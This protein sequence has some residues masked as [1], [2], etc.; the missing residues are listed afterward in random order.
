MWRSW[1]PGDLAHGQNHTYSTTLV[2]PESRTSPFKGRP[3]PAAT[4]L[5]L[6]SMT[7]TTKV[8]FKWSPGLP[9]TTSR[10]LL[11][12][13][14]TTC[15]PLVLETS[16]ECR[17][18]FPQTHIFRHMWGSWRPGSWPKPHLFDHLNVAGIPYKT[19]LRKVFG[20]APLHFASLFYNKTNMAFLWSPGLPATTSKHTV[21]HGSW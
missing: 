7:K 9:A 11:T 5:L 10:Q 16:I 3:S 8:V 6:S 20:P 4:P 17:L 19:I 21:V 18:K 13:L 2:L 14:L 1:R 12:N 15:I